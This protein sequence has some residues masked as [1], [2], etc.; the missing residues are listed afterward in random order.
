MMAQR[1]YVYP[2]INPANRVLTRLTRGLRVGERRSAGRVT[3][4]APRE[5]Q[6]SVEVQGD[7][8][9]PSENFDF[10]RV[11][12]PLSKGFYPFYGNGR[13]VPLHRDQRG[14]VKVDEWDREAYEWIR[15]RAERLVRGLMRRG[16]RR[17]RE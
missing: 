15:G 16:R 2:I 17:G 14:G 9:F 7:D 1:I 8:G 13:G 11:D 5:G 6:F 10:L 12:D 4:S 3:V